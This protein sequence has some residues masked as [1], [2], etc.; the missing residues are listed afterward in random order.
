MDDHLPPYF[1]TCSIGDT[2]LQADML[3][4]PRPGAL[5][6]HGWDGAR[7]DMHGP[8]CEAAA[9]GFR[10][11]APDLRGHGR[12]RAQRPEVTLRQMLDDTVVAHDLLLA[13]AG[14]ESDALAVIGTSVGGWLAAVLSG[15]RPVRWLALRVPAL[16]PDA[17]WD[18]P[19]DAFD[20]DALTAYRER[21]PVAA[22]D[23]AL[24]ACARFEGDVLLVWSGRDG[25]LPRCVADSY[26]LAFPRAASLVIRELPEADHA[27]SD[28]LQQERYRRLLGD[29]LGEGLL[30]RME[31]RATGTHPG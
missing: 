17:W 3:Q 30:H 21:G 22:T 29:W 6:L 8:M 26:Q 11:V 14:V 9:R 16:Y 13:A 7:S 18:I 4:P 15:M 20:R 25:V 1:S 2:A 24:H 12:S 27:L 10:C 23:R 31:A 5:F 28:P 19:K